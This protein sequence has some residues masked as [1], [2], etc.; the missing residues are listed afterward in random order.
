MR[1]AAVEYLDPCDAQG[2]ALLLWKLGRLE[3]LEE[4]L[5]HKQIYVP[6]LGK[7]FISRQP[8]LQHSSIDENN[9]GLPGIAQAI[10]VLLKKQ[11]AQANFDPCRPILTCAGQF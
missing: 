4:L 10:S 5:Q 1:C 7:S 11:P 2:K 3:P 9:F 8:P 6:L